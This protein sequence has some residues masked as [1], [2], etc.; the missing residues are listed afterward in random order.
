MPEE[1][2]PIIRISGDRIV[3][4]DQAMAVAEIRIAGALNMLPTYYVKAIPA[5]VDSD[6]IRPDT[7]LDT[8]DAWADLVNR[9]DVTANLNAEVRL[10]SAAGVD[11]YP[12]ELSNLI[13]KN[14]SPAYSVQG[15]LS[16]IDL[17][18]VHS[19]AASDHAG[20]SLGLAAPRRV[21]TNAVRIK[22]SANV[23]EAILEVLNEALIVIDEATDTTDIEAYEEFRT[24]LSTEGARA[25]EALKDNFVWGVKSNGFPI[26]TLSGDIQSTLK[27]YIPELVAEEVM[28][29][30]STPFQA[31]TTVMRSYGLVFNYTPWSVDPI[32]I[33]AVNPWRKDS[34]E[35]K[36]QD[37]A[38][39]SSSFVSSPIIGMYNM[40]NIPTD[41]SEIEDSITGG[42]GI[43][44]SRLV[45]GVTNI[46]AS[47]YY[48]SISA[49]YVPHWVGLYVQRKVALQK[50]EPDTS[51][52]IQRTP[53]DSVTSVA[54]LSHADFIEQTT[55]TNHFMTEDFTTKYQ[56]AAI[57]YTA[58][59]TPELLRSLAIGM[60]RYISRDGENLYKG[61]IS[62]MSLT[63]NPQGKTASMSV[64][65]THTMSPKGIP[66]IGITSAHFADGRTEKLYNSNELEA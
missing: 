28:N 44:G 55:L 50:F 2:T 34:G 54:R 21:S 33:V 38:Q 35:L 19:A 17:T 66:A 39:L 5:D 22:S 62:N 25:I 64:A 58:P 61:Y 36:L 42:I 40:T 31:L 49:A 4:G 56:S 37:G 7:L 48:G 46:A 23:L 8:V 26:T 59:A 20:Y 45:G 53:G 63:L 52:N 6:I 11:V 60:T 65:L 1:L 51:L 12:I 29:V 32:T 16:N 41:P 14:V 18:F 9:I 47:G 10:E 13:L 15:Q 27:Q 3:A 43:Q 30:N 24:F 57:Q